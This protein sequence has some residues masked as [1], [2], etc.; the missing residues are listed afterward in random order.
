MKLNDKVYEVLKW[1][2][3]IVLPAISTA[4]FGLAQIWGFP[5]AEQICGTLAIVETFIGTLIGVSTKAY[6]KEQSN[7]EDKD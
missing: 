2:V 1:I 3:V 6:R 5:Y 4:Y 7:G